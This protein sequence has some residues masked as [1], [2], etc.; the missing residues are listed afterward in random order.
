MS[1]ERYRLNVDILG[2]KSTVA[3]IMLGMNDIGRGDYDPAKT[4]PENDARR[5]ASLATYHDNM[6]KLIE[7]LQKIRHARLI[8]ITP[9]DL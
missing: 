8:L 3:S 2:K 7:S 1:D 4:G 6:Q 5:A 9:S